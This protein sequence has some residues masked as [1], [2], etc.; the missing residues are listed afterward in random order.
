M[1]HRDL[2][3]PDYRAFTHRVVVYVLEIPGANTDINAIV[4]SSVVGGN[5][6]TDLA[7]VR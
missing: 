3:V 2:A 5:A 1:I 4:A 6:R 7:V